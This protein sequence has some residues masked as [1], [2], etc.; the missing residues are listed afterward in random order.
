MRRYVNLNRII[1]RAERKKRSVT[2]ETFP[3]SSDGSLKG[4][5]S[6]IQTWSVRYDGY[7]DYKENET[8]DYDFA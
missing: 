5:G 6:S 3:K 8:Y 7:V 4:L 1:M 2:V